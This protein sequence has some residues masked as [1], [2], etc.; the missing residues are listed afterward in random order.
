MSTSA[1]IF[2]IL[3]LLVTWGGAAICILIALKKKTHQEILNESEVLK[4]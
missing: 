2:M 3:S 4:H 1:I